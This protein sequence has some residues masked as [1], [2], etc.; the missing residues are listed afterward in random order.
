MNVRGLN[1]ILLGLSNYHPIVIEGMGY[2]DP[3]AP[4]DVAKQIQSQLNQ[5]FEKRTPIEKPKL[6]ITQGDPLSK[7]GISAI[8]PLVANL[9]GVRRGLVT[10]DLDPQ[11][12]LNADRQNVILEV[13]Y[14]QMAN[15]L[16][17]SIAKG[18]TIKLEQEIDRQIVYK[19]K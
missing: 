13:S 18:T 12:S 10:L 17:S 14:S 1:N 15:I 9:L 16:E 5:H 8:T 3:R 4:L 11:H 2:Y 7:R 6:I 19:N